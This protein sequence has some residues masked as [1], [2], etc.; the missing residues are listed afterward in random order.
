M[1]GTG[2]AETF[3]TIHEN[4]AIVV[5]TGRFHDHEGSLDSVNMNVQAGGRVTVTSATS[6]LEMFW[7]NPGGTATRT[8]HHR[9]MVA[10]REARPLHPRQLVRQA[11]GTPRARPGAYAFLAAPV[12]PPA[13]GPPVTHTGFMVVMGVERFPRTRQQ[14]WSAHAPGAGMFSLTPLPGVATGF[15]G[16]R[17][18][19]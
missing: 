19:R 2:D 5:G 18:L 16:T 9:T 1:I 17:F 11:F 13:V 14:G 7:E 10:I 3:Y 4:G 12:L 6:D 8:I 15:V